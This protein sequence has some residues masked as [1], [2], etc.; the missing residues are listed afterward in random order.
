VGYSTRL[1]IEIGTF[2]EKF[3]KTL[4]IRTLKLNSTRIFRRSIKE[5]KQEFVFC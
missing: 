4:C 5:L 3:K 1:R 2:A